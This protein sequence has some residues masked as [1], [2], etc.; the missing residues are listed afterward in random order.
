MT[1]RSVHD[2]D[3]LTR[4]DRTAQEWI[5]TVAERLRTEDR[6][7][8]YR[9][10]RAWLR[11]VRDRLGVDA[12]AHFSAQLPVLLRGVY[13]DG[14]SPSH[15]PVKYDAEQLLV[16]IAQ[17]ARLS[18][19]EAER[20]V[21]AITDALSRRCSPGQIEHLLAQL[22]GPLRELLTPADGGAEATP[23]DRATAAPPAPEAAARARP[24]PEVTDR[25]ERVEQQLEATTE[26]LRT[27]LHGLEQRPSDETRPER[28]TAAVHR[29]HQILL[30]L[31]T[32][33]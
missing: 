22:P 11:T 23:A 19:A 18:V 26:A 16:T 24:D 29:A 33:D 32:R 21:P 12:A 17:E 25:L 3:T 2:I 31:G 7:H 13:F 6:N 30:S 27:L 5:D 1:D 8:A 20:A 14:W 4:A 28:S 9:V 15:V 10:L